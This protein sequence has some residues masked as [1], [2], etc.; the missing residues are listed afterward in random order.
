LSSFF[1]KIKDGASKAADKAHQALEIN[2]LNLQISMV[3]KD[4]DK[5]YN[6]IGQSVFR[7]YSNGDV[8]QADNDI[9][10]FSQQIVNHG[11]SIAEIEQKIKEVKRE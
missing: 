9:A 10:K 2:R 11:M 6:Q 5:A 3:R 7:A 4:I 8:S 1:D